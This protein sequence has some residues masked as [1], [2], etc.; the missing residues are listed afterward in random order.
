MKNEHNSE[1]VNMR[2]Q[3]PDHVKDANGDAWGTETDIGYVQL[4]AGG[5][6]IYTAHGWEY[7]SEAH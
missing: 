1:R 6:L 2:A 3:A 7:R 5:V 4:D